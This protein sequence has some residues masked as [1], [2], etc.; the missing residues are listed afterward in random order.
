MELERTEL[1]NL[2]CRSRIQEWL[3]R[4]DEVLREE[5][6]VLDGL[7]QAVERGTMTD[8]EATVNFIAYRDNLH[9]N[10]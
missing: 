2:D 4:T 6:I 10:T 3:Q 7:R 9:G 1:A 8:D 5:E